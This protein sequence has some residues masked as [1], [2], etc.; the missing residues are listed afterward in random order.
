MLVPKPYL[1][2]LLLKRETVLDGTTYPFAIPAV[3]HLL[4]KT[5]CQKFVLNRH[6]PACGLPGPSG[7]R[8]LT[9]GGSDVFVATEIERIE[10]E[11]GF[12]PPIIDSYGEH[13]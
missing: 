2:E 9:H 13:S 12:A 5:T 6:A 1:R 11:P 8:M 4:S 7:I 3:R 10:K